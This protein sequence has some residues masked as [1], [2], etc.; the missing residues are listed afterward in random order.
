MGS[1]RI[2]IGS[3]TMTRTAGGVT[4][5]KALPQLS[6][7]IDFASDG[8]IGPGKISLLEQIDALG[9]ISAAGRALNMSYKR[10]WDLVEEMTRICGVVVARQT[11][12]RDG[13]GSVL[14]PLGVSLVE[15]YRRIE[16]AATAAVREDLV[17]L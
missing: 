6:I 8:R 11:G 2:G 9:S 12:G 16:K 10:A 4:R 7:R 15:R 3:A 17:K 1:G 14:T 13:G 5:R